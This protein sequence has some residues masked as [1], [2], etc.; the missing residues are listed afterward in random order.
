MKTRARPI[1][2]EDFRV[3]PIQRIRFF[4]NEIAVLRALHE[5]ADL[6]EVALINYQDIKDVELLRKLKRL[7]SPLKDKILF[8]SDITC[9]EPNIIHYCISSDRAAILFFNEIYYP[10]WTLKDDGREI[11][12]FRVNHTFRGAYLEP[13]Q[14]QLSMTFSPKSFKVGLSATILGLTFCGLILGPW[15]KLRSKMIKK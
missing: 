2:N 13:G 15:D 10:G 12:L 14:Y 5:D 7:P 4:D 8:S 3:I 1:I 9:Y 6:H 11:P